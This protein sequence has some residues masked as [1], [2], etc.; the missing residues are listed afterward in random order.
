MAVTTETKPESLSS[1]EQDRALLFTQFLDVEYASHT[2]A[3]PGIIE[4]EIAD[5]L[6]KHPGLSRTLQKAHAYRIVAEKCRLHI[7]PVDWFAGDFEHARMLIRQRQEWL[8]ELEAGPLAKE[9]RWFDQVFRIGALRGRL[10]FGHVAPGWENLFDA[11]LDGIIDRAGG[12]LDRLGEGAPPEQ[13][14]FLEA[15]VIVSRASIELA[16]RF[17]G[18]ARRLAD[19]G[20]GGGNNLRRMAAVLDRVPAG[21]PEGLR[22]AL[23]FLWFFQVLVEFE[24]EQ[25][26][27]FGH[28]DRMLFPYYRDDVDSGR[29]TRAGAKELLKYFLFKFQARRQG[30]GDSARNFTIAGQTAG[31]EDATNELTYVILE[32]VEEINTPDPKMS[33]RFHPGTPNR[34]YRRVA[35]LIQKGCNSLVL[36]NDPPT[37]EGLMKHGKTLEDA[38]TY[39]SI[40]CYEPAIDGK[41]MA[42][43]MNIP[44]NLAKPIELMLNDG[45]DP[46]SGERVGVRTGPVE[47]F[48]SFDDVYG[49]YTAQIDHLLTRTFEYLTT[50]EGYWTEINPSPLIASTID[51]CIERAMDIGAG[52]CRYNSV[53]CPAGALA[54][55]S[56]SLLAIRQAVFE[57]GRYSIEQL[58]K[59]VAEDF[60]GHETMRQYLVNQ[61]PKWGTNDPRADELARKVADHYCDTLSGFRTSRNGPYQPGLFALHFQW[62]FGR[63]TGALPC[64]RKSRTPTAPGIGAGP[65]MDIS[66][67]TSLMGSVE[68]LDFTRAPNGSVLDVMLHPTSIKGENGID[69][70]C[71]LIK[72]H[73]AKGGNYLQ[74]NVVDT[75]T[76]VDA[77]INPERHAGLQVRITGYSAYFTKISKFEQDLF[78]ERNKHA[79]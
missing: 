41:D 37:I 66:G 60:E 44:V 43:T 12:R 58:A 52:G 39:L 55:A 3:A 68:K 22:E 10:D 20:V 25:T 11:G 63:N 69:N 57:E 70:L 34:L 26:M 27:S 78:I 61:I 18:E 79:L 45:V 75:G 30:T 59:A 35:E 21:R 67:I 49:G 32:A 16:R 73:F 36:M 64:G 15:V 62:T 77:Q 24:G 29:L 1:F 5:F 2:G 17:A 31:G 9:A 74:F 54:E 50:Y 53:G 4:G 28:F 38:R 65:G 33:I 8:D 56:D 23:Q 46:L 71:A 42:C 13:R 48:T 51:D 72:T 47:S 6:S 14:D 76:L 7:D 19:S 40:G